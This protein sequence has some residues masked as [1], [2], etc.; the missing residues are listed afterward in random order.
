M[1]L[2]NLKI[3]FTGHNGNRLSKKKDGIR[4][5][6]RSE[7]ERMARIIDSLREKYLLKDLLSYLKFPKS[8]YMY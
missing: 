6:G 4:G 3:S 2:L 7:N 8:T 5:R 1:K